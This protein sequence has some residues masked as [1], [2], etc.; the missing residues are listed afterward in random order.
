[1][2]CDTLNKKN[3]CLRVRSGVLS[4]LPVADKA[5]ATVW[6]RNP[7][8]KTTTNQQLRLLNCWK[9]VKKSQHG[10]SLFTFL[11]SLTFLNTFFNPSLF[12]LFPLTHFSP[13]STT[14]F[15]FLLNHSLPPF[16]QSL[17]PSL[18]SITHFSPC[19]RV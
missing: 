1:M 18:F 12:S 16:F 2:K 8:N 10:G 13:F 14:Q 19:F 5:V 11:Q 7:E 15:S 4:T 9:S 6:T 3:V 17:T